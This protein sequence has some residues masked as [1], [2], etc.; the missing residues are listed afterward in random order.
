MTKKNIK[1]A[2][3]STPKPATSQAGMSTLIRECVSDGLGKTATFEKFAKKFPGFAMD[4]PHFA[5][6][7]DNNSGKKATKPAAKPAKSGKKA[8][9]PPAPAKKSATKK[10]T[11]PAPR[12]PV[13]PAPEA[14]PVQIEIPA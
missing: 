7:W 11:P 5:N 3:K 1:T 14:E 9:T 6:R 13:A 12:V 10:P 4:H 2:V 8:A